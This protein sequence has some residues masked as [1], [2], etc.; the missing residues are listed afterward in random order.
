MIPEGWKLVPV[1]P[2]LEMLEEGGECMTCSSNDVWRAMLTA[3]PTIT[4]QVQ[5]GSCGN[6]ECN[7]RGELNECSYLGAIGPC[8]PKCREIVEPDH[9][10]EIGGKVDG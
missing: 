4:D 5:Y 3:S 6:G 10:S 7:W 2:T 1:E 9:A 8:C